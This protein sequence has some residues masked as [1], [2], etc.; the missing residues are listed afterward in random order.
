VRHLLTEGIKRRAPKLG[1]PYDDSVLT[2]VDTRDDIRAALAF[3]AAR[4][5]RLANWVA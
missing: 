5:R 1:A 4:E 3:A 2:S